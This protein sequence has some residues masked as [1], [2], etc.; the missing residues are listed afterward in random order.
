MEVI[1]SYDDSGYLVVSKIVENIS[2]NIKNATAEATDDNF[3]IIVTYNNGHKYQVSSSGEINVLT[4]WYSSDTL[5][6]ESSVNT[7]TNLPYSPFMYIDPTT[8]SLTQNKTI[9]AVRLIPGAAGSITFSIY[10]YIDASY[11]SY[12]NVSP[13]STQTIT[14]SSGDVSAGGVHT[15]LLEKPVYIAY[16]EMWC[17]SSTSDTGKFKYVHNTGGL[18]AHPFC[19]RVGATAQMSNNGDVLTVDVGYVATE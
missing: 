4:V 9:N 5:E 1:A 11:S 12:K 13:V 3:P 6:L 18:S 16:D 10:K 7:N 14:I 17:I 15:Y 8:Q 2:S 19:C